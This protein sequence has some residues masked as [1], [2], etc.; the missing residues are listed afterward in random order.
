MTATATIQAPPRASYRLSFGGLLNSEWI[1]LRT[2]RS[3][4]WSFAIMIL[5]SGGLGLLMASTIDTA[6]TGDFAMSPLNV[7]QAA[8]SGSVMFG[9]LIAAVLGALVITGEYSTGMIRTTLTAAP[10]RLGAFIAKAVVLFISTGIVALVSAAASYLAVALILMGRGQ[11]APLFDGDV[12]PH[13]LGGALYVA[14]VALFALG[15]GTLIRSGAGAIAGALGT[16]LVLPLVLALVPVEW[17]NNLRPFLLDAA[18]SRLSSGMMGDDWTF[19]TSALLMAGW[20]LVSLILGAFALL[21][22]DA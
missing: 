5:L 11:S 20:T 13:V 16:I 12:L 6:G 2:L 8:T 22:R 19:A 9:Q 14:C 17:I 15:L 3:T 10:K 1:K 7:V 4:L 21:K 18:G